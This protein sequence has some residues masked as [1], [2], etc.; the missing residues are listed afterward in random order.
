MDSIVFI[1]VCFVAMSDS[2]AFIEIPVM[3]PGHHGTFPGPLD[4][5]PGEIL[6]IPW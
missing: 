4:P 3:F 5:F 1:I 2:Y 6:A